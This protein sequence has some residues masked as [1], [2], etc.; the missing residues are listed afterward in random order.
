MASDKRRESQQYWEAR[1]KRMNL[2][3]DRGRLKWLCYEHITGPLPD[4]DGKR[5]YTA[6][7]VEDLNEWPI[8]L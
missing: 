7:D 2:D 8:S 6:Q 1:L 5:T 3:I 4:F